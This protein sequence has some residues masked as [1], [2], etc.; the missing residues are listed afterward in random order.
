MTQQ[1]AQENWHQG[2]VA[3][4]T[5]GNDGIGR[6]IARDLSRRGALVAV[7]ARRCGDRRV[8]EAVLRETGAAHARA[9][10]V[11]DDASVR[12]FLDAV[13]GRLG[14]PAILVNAAG[15]SVHMDVAGHDPH[16]WQDVLDTNLTGPFRMIGACLPAML[17]AGWGRIVNIASTAARAA[18]PGHA[19]YCASKSGLL[20]LTRTVA[21]EGAARGVTA[22]AVSPTWVETDMLRA[23]AAEHATKAGT[24]I[25]TEIMAIAQSNPQQRLVQPPE[26]AALVSFLCSNLAPALTMEDI[27]V[28]AG[29]HW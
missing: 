5:G 28:N 18:E 25:N 19:A 8:A 3:I 4:V 6:A 24:D 23:S 21:L 20:G 7:G 14:A 15:I 16:A 17:E 27:Q 12:A 10:D 26:I 22:V 9:L 13:R 1:T 11:R 29:A 2:R